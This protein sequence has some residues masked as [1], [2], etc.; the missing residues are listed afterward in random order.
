MKVNGIDFVKYSSHFEKQEGVVG[1][2]IA[3]SEAVASCTVKYIRGKDVYTNLVNTEYCVLSEEESEIV[4]D[5][6]LD[7]SKKSIV[8]DLNKWSMNDKKVKVWLD[9]LTTLALFPKTML[10]ESLNKTVENLREFNLYLACYIRWYSSFFSLPTKKQSTVRFKSMW[11]MIDYSEDYDMT[12]FE[13][14]LVELKRVIENL[15]ECV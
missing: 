12:L 14:T 9:P 6:E 1:L 7:Y 2:F 8:N 4:T 10:L 13:E 3:S 11:N 5:E 15:Q